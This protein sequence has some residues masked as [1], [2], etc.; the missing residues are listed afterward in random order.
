MMEDAAPAETPA[1]D[2]L[3][4][5]MDVSNRAGYFNFCQVMAM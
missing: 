2:V 5:P 3:W 1:E 4:D